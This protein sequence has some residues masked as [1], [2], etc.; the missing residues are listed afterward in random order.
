[1]P[2][3]RL[4]RAKQYADRLRAYQILIDD[5]KAGE[6][7]A[8]ATVELVV[9]EGTHRIAVKLDWCRSDEIVFN[10]RGDEVLELSCANR[11]GAWLAFFY[12][13]FAPRQYLRLE[14]TDGKV[15]NR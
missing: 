5:E 9:G 4:H 6:I 3:I 11:S 15:T 10:L 2:S 13:M 7:K 12:V 14:K 8:G 1:M